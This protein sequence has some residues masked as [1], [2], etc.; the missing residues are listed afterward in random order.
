MVKFTVQYHNTS[1]GTATILRDGQPVSTYSQF[2][3]CKEKPYPEWIADFPSYCR[4][5]ANGT[6]EVHFCGDEFVALLLKGFLARSGSCHS[7]TY[8]PPRI[9]EL[10]RLSFLR[11]ALT[12]VHEQ[13]PSAMIPFIAASDLLIQRIGLQHTPEG[14]RIPAWHDHPIYMKRVNHLLNIYTNIRNDVIDMLYLADSIDEVRQ[15]DRKGFYG[16]FALILSNTDADEGIVNG[17]FTIRCTPVSAQR[18]IHAWACSRILPTFIESCSH[19]LIIQ[20]SAEDGIMKGML[21]SDDPCVELLSIPE[22]MFVGEQATATILKMPPDMECTLEVSSGHG[23][24]LE[25]GGL[26][27]AI[28]AEKQNIVTLRSRQW[29]DVY[30]QCTIMTLFR[31]HVQQVS[32]SGVPHQ[33]VVGESFSA[34]YQFSPSDSLDRNIVRWQTHPAGILQDHGN[35]RFT[36]VAVGYATISLQVG[37]IRTT[38]TTHVQPAAEHIRLSGTQV[39]CKLPDHWQFLH[40]DILPKDA[41]DGQLTYEMD[42][43][44]LAEYD[45][46]LKKLYP[47]SAG[48]GE[49]IV[50]L[51]N[52]AGRVVD[53]Q[54]CSV[55]VLPPDKIYQPL[56]AFIALLLATI[57]TWWTSSPMNIL[58]AT[59]SCATLVWLMFCY[60]E[61]WQ[62]VGLGCAI[63]VILMTIMT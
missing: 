50:R 55:T 33:L 59:I 27:T 43:P 24:R 52:R 3:V 25:L 48:T 9:D 35:G 4:Q 63:L 1:E 19:R 18:W 47:R 36:A 28:D 16:G 51:T 21:F 42:P 31:H 32:L 40:A 30:D 13:M 6:Y 12:Y 10:S 46:V 5:E 29:P 56:C 11:I 45:P 23:L 58:F 7:F 39:T 2:Y 20:R 62:R 60:K 34:S 38:A 22:V 57:G 14:D 53:E 37:K 61:P 17:W 26:V 54:K 41:G 49:W 15:M 8:S 44:D